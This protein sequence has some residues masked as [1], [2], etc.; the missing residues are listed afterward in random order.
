MSDTRD[1]VE[2]LRDPSQPRGGYCDSVQCDKV[3]EEAAA[4]IVRLRESLNVV[5]ACLSE[6]GKGLEKHLLKRTPGPETKEV[7]SE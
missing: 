1:I 7:G 4:E 6:M 3:K 5:A 2:R